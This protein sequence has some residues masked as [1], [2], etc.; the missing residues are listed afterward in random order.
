MLRLL[1]FKG[2]RSIFYISHFYLVIF[3]VFSIAVSIPRI[4]EFCAYYIKLE[5]LIMVQKISNVAKEDRNGL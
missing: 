5:G 1:F 3:L 4:T 2:R